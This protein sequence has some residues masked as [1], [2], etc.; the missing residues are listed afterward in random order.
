MHL[1]TI[2]EVLKTLDVSTR[3]ELIVFNKIDA[4]D[5]DTLEKLKKKYPKALFISAYKQVKI[6]E[7]LDSIQERLSTLNIISQ[8]DLP[9]S[10]LFL[11]DYIYNPGNILKLKAKIK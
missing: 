4:V 9:Y 1:A 7:L 11:I 8:I 6:N 3:L 2:N 10:K 5:I